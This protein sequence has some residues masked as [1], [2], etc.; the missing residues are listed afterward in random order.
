M[1]RL[2][3]QRVLV[4]GGAGFIGSRLC[5]RLSSQGA[6]VTAFDSLLAQVH[7]DS[8]ELDPELDLIQG[9]VRDRVALS[10]AIEAVRPQIVFHLA[11]ETGTGQSADEPSRYADVNVV[12]TALLIE[13]LK[14]LDQPPTRVVLAA[15][16]AVYGEGAYRDERGTVLAP[17][18]R[19]I[20]AMARGQFGVVDAKGRPLI[21]VPT[22]DS[23]SPRPGSVY[24]ST[25]LM[26]EYLLQQTPV[27]WDTVILRLQNVYG[28]GQSLRNPYTGVLSIFCQQAMEVRGL[29]IYE[30]GEIYRDFVFVED[31]VDAFALAADAEGAAGRIVNIGSGLKTSIREAAEVILQNLGRDPKVAITGAYRAGDI[32]HAVADIAAARQ[33]LD[34]A[35]RTSFE[36]GVSQLVEWAKGSSN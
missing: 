16:R 12:G 21:A 14:A 20:E 35:P 4:T 7:G 11:A 33:T 26:Q 34:W 17:P 25:K 10:G 28:P 32:R 24:G 8:P 18:P 3:G 1:S 29:G 13:G 36:S 2:N 19:S 30:D 23:L 31:V 5:R 9:D 22:D 27:P 15:T 6:R